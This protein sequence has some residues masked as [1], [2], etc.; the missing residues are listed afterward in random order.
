[1]RD[2]R[3]D[4]SINK[5]YIII[6]IVAALVVGAVIFVVAD[7]FIGQKE[8]S[9]AVCE[10]GCTI[11]H[12]H[13]YDNDTYDVIDYT[14]NEPKGASKYE[15]GTAEYDLR[16]EELK[17]TEYKELYAFLFEVNS[18]LSNTTNPVEPV[19]DDRTDDLK[20]CA[21]HLIDTTTFQYHEDLQDSLRKYIASID[22]YREGYMSKADF[23]GMTQGQKNNIDVFLTELAPK[24]IEDK[25]ASEEGALTP[26]KTL[27][28]AKAAIV[29]SIFVLLVSI[30]IILKK[31]R[32]E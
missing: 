3:E 1:M 14:D 31:L 15:K 25:Y 4:T 8:T 26:S 17:R 9:T 24:E 21:Q 13:H 18:F 27:T 32:S 16:L 2:E 20:I 10:D 22:A 19:D 29:V 5:L 7:N 30:F 28:Y 23:V 6:A 11:D 12:E